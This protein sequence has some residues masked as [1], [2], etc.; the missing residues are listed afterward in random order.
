MCESPSPA[1]SNSDR[2][3]SPTGTPPH[4]GFQTPN[5][6][7][8]STGSGGPSLAGWPRQIRWGEFRGVSR[9]PG[10][11][12]E[13]AQISVELRGGRVRVERE[14]GQFRLG[15]T[16]FRIRTNRR[17]SWVVTNKKSDALLEHEQGHYDLAGLCYR[18]LVKELRSIRTNSVRE[19]QSEIHRLMEEYDQ[20]SD[21]LSAQYDDDTGHGTSTERQDAWEN[22]MQDAIRND[23]PFQAPG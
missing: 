12:S 1:R 8:V 21:D 3:E 5:P 13:D 17:Q 15:R 22:S 6:H 4:A 19:L 14:N 20:R 16:T 23:T 10:G 2:T 9:R 7:G 11:A 18:D